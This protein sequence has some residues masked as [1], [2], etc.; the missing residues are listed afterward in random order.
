SPITCPDGT[1]TCIRVD[2]MRGIIGR[3]GAAHMNTIPTFMMGIVGLSSQGVRATA[4]AQ[5]AGGNAV[6][7]IKP[8][9]VADK[10]VDSSGTGSNTSG[11]DQEDIWNDGVDSYT[12]PGFKATGTGNDY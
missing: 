5:V 6:Q 12:S 3:D 7:C 8:W 2:G 9:V 10:W 11:W 1:N 4:T